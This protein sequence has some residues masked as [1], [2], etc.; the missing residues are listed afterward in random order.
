MSYD[1]LFKEYLDIYHTTSVNALFIWTLTLDINISVFLLFYDKK[2]SWSFSEMYSI[3]YS[4]PTT[5]YNNSWIK[6]QKSLDVW[7]LLQEYYKGTLKLNF[8]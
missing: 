8:I 6:K 2:W 1:N 7:A 4:D 5:N 3:T